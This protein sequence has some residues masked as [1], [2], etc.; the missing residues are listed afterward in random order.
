MAYIWHIYGIYMAYTTIL[1]HY[2]P[3]DMTSSSCPLDAK[4]RQPGMSKFAKQ[5]QVDLVFS[6]TSRP[7]DS[8]EG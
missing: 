8:M 5:Q 7:Q 6:A 3:L 4:L 2:S 1:L